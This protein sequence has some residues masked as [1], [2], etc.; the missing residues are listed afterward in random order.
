MS[1]CFSWFCKTVQHYSL[2]Q[3]RLGVLSPKLTVLGKTDFSRL[4]IACECRS[5]CASHCQLK[6]LFASGCSFL[7]LLLRAASFQV[8]CF[9]KLCDNEK[10]SLWGFWFALVGYWGKFSLPL[11]PLAVISSGTKMLDLFME[12]VITFRDIAEDQSS[13]AGLQKANIGAMSKVQ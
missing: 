2:W 1:T 13:P 12:W 8:W 6:G 5:F 3:K 4:W 11:P 9:L 7:S 10:V